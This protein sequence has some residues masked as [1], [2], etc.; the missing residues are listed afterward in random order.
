MVSAILLLIIFEIPQRRQLNCQLFD[1][2][3]YDQANLAGTTDDPYLKSE[4]VKI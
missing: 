4:D 1:F 2:S 3:E